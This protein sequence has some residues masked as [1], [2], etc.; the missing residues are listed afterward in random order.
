MA[1]QTENGPAAQAPAGR[2]LND[3]HMALLLAHLRGGSA[4]PPNG[5]PPRDDNPL[6]TQLLAAHPP[7]V[8]DEAEAQAA[9]DWEQFNWHVLLA[10]Q[11]AHIGAQLPQTQY[12]GFKRG[13]A[14]VIA[15]CIYFF[16]RMIVNPQRQFNVS[17]LDSLRCMQCTIRDLERNLANAT[18]PLEQ[19]IQRLE[20]AL[21]EQKKQSSQ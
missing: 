19:R 13:V 17:V 6:I 21:Q 20:Q 16:T 15:R 7:T 9:A 8:S 4:V 3:Y 10:E 11:N 2:A 14:R 12:G 5:Q 1:E 18:R